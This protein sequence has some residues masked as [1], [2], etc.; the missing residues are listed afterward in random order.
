[1]VLGAGEF[2]AYIA[3]EFKKWDKVVKTAAIKPE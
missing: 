3:A 1:M 2:R